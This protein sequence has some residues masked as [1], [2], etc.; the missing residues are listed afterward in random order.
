MP[1][2]VGLIKTVNNQSF[3]P[4][5]L[6]LHDWFDRPSS[7]VVAMEHPN[8]CKD[9]YSYCQDQGDVLNEDEACNITRQLLGPLQHCEDSGIV[10]RDVKLENILIQTDTKDI[11]LI[12]FGCGDRLKDTPYTEFSVHIYN[13]TQFA[14]L[15]GTECYQPLEWFKEEKFLAGPRNVWSVG[16]T[17]YG[18]VCGQLPFTTFILKRMQEVNLPAGLSAGQRDFILCCLRPNAEDRPTLGQLQLHPWLQL[19]YCK[20]PGLSP[21]QFQIQT[22]RSGAH[23]NSEGGM[24]GGILTPYTFEYH[25]VTI[26]CPAKRFIAAI[27]HPPGPLGNFMDELDTLLSSFLEDLL[28]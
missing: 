22:A 27:C 5:I 21:P 19:E 24:L 15:S 1:R 26:T 12:D 9:L 4:N 7:Y 28:G 2:E 6:K 17:V 14:C 25:S 16:I 23:R 3:H 8:P 11:K 18:M 20:P 10:H 13:V